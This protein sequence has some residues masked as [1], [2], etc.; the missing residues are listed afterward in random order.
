MAQLP[1]GDVPT[2]PSSQHCHTGHQ[3]SSMAALPGNVEMRSAYTQCPG[4]QGPAER[5][6]DGH[7][8]V[9]P[10]RAALLARP[11][12][13]EPFLGTCPRGRRL[14]LTLILALGGLTPGICCDKLPKMVD[15]DGHG[16]L[17]HRLGSLGHERQRSPGGERRNGLGTLHREKRGP[18]AQVLGPETPWP[19]AR[20]LAGVRVDGPVEW[21]WLF[22]NSRTGH[23][24]CR[25]Q[26][27][28]E[29]RPGAAL[30]GR[31]PWPHTVPAP[32]LGDTQP[33][34]HPSSPRHR[35]SSS[36]PG[37][38]SACSRGWTTRFPPSQGTEVSVAMAITPSKA[39]R[40]WCS[41][42]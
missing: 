6:H 8:P 25:S 12:G 13:A 16:H 28:P 9:T 15:H 21:P 35:Q 7:T 31:E 5:G 23:C 18:M 34:R 32:A 10:G 14:P 36:A 38:V 29:G 37:Q 3:A 30:E 27:P 2:A 24:E 26:A 1:L 39:C 42:R 41:P 40:P 17:G 33:P 11:H 20:G 19:R 22:W 4:A